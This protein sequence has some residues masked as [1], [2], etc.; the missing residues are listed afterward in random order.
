MCPKE[1]TL[2]ARLKYSQT[3]REIWI[4][5]RPNSWIYVLFWHQFSSW[6]TF[7]PIFADIQILLKN[8]FNELF[9]HFNIVLDSLLL[10]LGFC[11]LIFTLA[12]LCNAANIKHLSVFRCGDLPFSEG[13]LCGCGAKNESLTFEK[14][15]LNLMDCEA[16]QYCFQKDHSLLSYV[17]IVIISK[18]FHY[19][20]LTVTYT[21]GPFTTILL[22]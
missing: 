5:W 3:W 11:L 17:I 20:N 21:D 13:D 18:G 6:L 7:W 12:P 10:D 19:K 16:S 2:G 14:M 22:G 9:W 8:T 15:A 1:V 4:F